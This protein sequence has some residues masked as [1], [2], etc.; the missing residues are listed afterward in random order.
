MSSPAD[1]G[2]SAPPAPADTAPASEPGTAANSTA[3]AAPAAPPAPAPEPAKMP[4]LPPGVVGLGW[5][6]GDGLFTPTK[7][8]GRGGFGTTYLA[9]KN[10]PGWPKL[11]IKEC[12]PTNGPDAKEN[13]RAE[14]LKLTQ[15]GGHHQ[16]PTCYGCYEE[17]DSLFLVQDFISGGDCWKQACEKVPRVVYDEEK[18]WELLVQTMNVLSYCHDKRNEAGGLVHRDI[19]P[20]NIMC[21]EEDGLYM[22]ID[23]G[24]V[25]DMAS[26][27]KEKDVEWCGT[28]GY[29]APEM[30]KGGAGKVYFCS[31]LYAM[32]ATVVFLMT[33]VEPMF[34]PQSDPNVPGV[35]E[36][37]SYMTWR[38]SP[39]LEYVVDKM[40][41]PNPA[42]RYQDAP[43]VL[44]SIDDLFAE[45]NK[46]S[47][48]IRY[49]HPQSPRPVELIEKARAR[50]LTQLGRDQ[51]APG[52]TH[53]R[54][55]Q[56][57]LNSYAPL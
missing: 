29:D 55:P 37:R 1:G 26:L 39:Q 40:L 9:Y 12:L 43:E 57:S 33:L 20:A 21:R 46:E 22:L 32:G 16:I 42:Q 45:A 6:I 30:G 18:I 36:W 52:L 34:M 41:A 38:A 35:L 19:K 54:T 51:S 25:K 24:A 8:L 31:D 28:A 49:Q 4:A 5:T 2:P 3:V 15:L 48:A 23:F 7:E 11:V 44:A 50:M 10:S 14:A 53:T 47:P 56:Q 13:F 17:R 27:R